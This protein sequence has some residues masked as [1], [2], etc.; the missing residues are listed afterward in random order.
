VQVELG[1]ASVSRIEVSSGLQRGDQ[2]IL[3]DISQWSDYDRVR[4]N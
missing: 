2:V 3:S 4:M 1:R